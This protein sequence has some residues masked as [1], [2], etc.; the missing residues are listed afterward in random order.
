MV[1]NE[2][3]KQWGKEGG[4]RKMREGK[5]RERRTMVKDKEGKVRGGRKAKYEE[6]EGQGK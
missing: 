3:W 6:G 4:K 1:K 5:E 2:E